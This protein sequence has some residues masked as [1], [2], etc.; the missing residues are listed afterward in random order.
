MGNMENLAYITYIL[1][2]REYV[3]TKRSFKRIENNR[4]RLRSKRQNHLLHFMCIQS[5]YIPH[6]NWFCLIVYDYIVN[7]IIYNVY[8]KLVMYKFIVYIQKYIYIDTKA[9]KHCVQFENNVKVIYYYS[10][11]CKWILLL[12]MVCSFRFLNA[13][14]FLLYLFCSLYIFL[15]HSRTVCACIWII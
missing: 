9:T 1:F 7:Y 5:F 13:H 12:F 10:H 8:N 3:K 15:S 4:K 14:A 2:I 6:K 11:F